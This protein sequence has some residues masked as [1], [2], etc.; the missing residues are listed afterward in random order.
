MAN[1]VESAEEDNDV[2]VGE[3]PDIPP[4]LRAALLGSWRKVAD[5]R[6]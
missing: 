1:T 6:Y 4:W 3:Y 5:V 2:P